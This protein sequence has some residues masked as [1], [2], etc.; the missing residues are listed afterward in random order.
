MGAGALSLILILNEAVLS[1][2]KL[3]L[4][5]KKC[6]MNVTKFI[7]CPAH[8]TSWAGFTVVSASFNWMENSI[9]KQ[10]NIFN[11]I[12]HY[13]DKIVNFSTII[14]ILDNLQNKNVSNSKFKSSADNTI[15]TKWQ[16]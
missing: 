2:L 3:P 7:S 6:V 9:F 4:H 8:C 16:I 14:D 1:Y 12:I 11:S 13:H 15:G 5:Y 10:D